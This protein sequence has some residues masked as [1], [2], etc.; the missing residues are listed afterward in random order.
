MK[1]VVKNA[2][3]GGTVAA[4]PS[5]SFAHRL[6][7]AACLSGERTTIENVGSS[8]DISATAA[9]LS[10]LGFDCRIDCGNAVIGEKKRSPKDTVF[11]GES[12][13]TLRFLLPVAAALGIQTEFTGD[14][15]LLKRPMSALVDCLNVRGADIRGLK[16]FGKLSSGSFII[17][18]SESSQYI[19]GL[20]FALPLLE[21]ESEIIISGGSVSAGYID[22][23]LSVLKDFGIKVEKT[24][25]GYKIKGGKYRLPE[26]IS[27]E[28]DYSGA[29]FFLAA[30]ALGKGVTVKNLN[31]VSVQGDRAI[32]DILSRF[33]AQVGVTEDGVTVKKSKLQG[34]EVDISPIPDLAQIIAVVAAFAEGKTVLKNVERLQIKESDRLSAII[35]TLS[36]VGIETAIFGNDLIIFGGKPHGAA[37]GGEK[38][39]RTV[40]SQTVLATFASGNSTVENVGAESK[41]YPEF[42]KD[43]AL[44]GGKTDVLF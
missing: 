13:S 37:L 29:A 7:I 24:D 15:G 17:D 11:C 10:A 28:G 23:T 9:A 19:T 38:D 34:I 2:N 44:I 8:A 31:P 16:I 30:G 27:V 20:L 43:F 41:S 6:I 1:A 25:S 32:V 3:V 22:I 33:G 21:G 18:G 26:R 4:P 35:K 12:G 5:K 39:H 42:Y 36:A 40:M 14:T